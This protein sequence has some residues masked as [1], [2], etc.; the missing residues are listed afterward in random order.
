MV[1]LSNFNLE[2]KKNVFEMNSNHDIITRLNKQVEYFQDNCRHCDSILL[3]LDSSN[4]NVSYVN[5]EVEILVKNMTSAFKE[6]DWTCDQL[7]TLSKKLKIDVD[8]LN[9]FVKTLRLSD[10]ELSNNLHNLASL[11]NEYSE[12][13]RSL[14]DAVIDMD[15]IMY[16]VDTNIREAILHVTLQ[17][18]SSIQALKALKPFKELKWAL[19]DLSSMLIK[20][21][22]LSSNM[23]D[24]VNVSS[25]AIIEVMHAVNVNFGYG[26]CTAMY[27][28][29]VIIFLK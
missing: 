5:K 11:E 13:L 22:H 14:V 15:Y 2:N 23:L 16:T 17:D 19:D 21:E 12:K 27:Y 4:F 6:T 29:F 25:D 7:L 20:F 9:E 28:L 8:S 24:I 26:F 18:R 1:T 3:K 10:I